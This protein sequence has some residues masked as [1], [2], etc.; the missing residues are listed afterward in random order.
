MLP[1]H[2]SPFSFPVH[3]SR[4]TVH[5]SSDSPMPASTHY[6]VIIIGTG[7][8]G[9]TL[10]HR[11]AP[12]GKRILLLERGDYVPRRTGQLEHAGGQCRGPGTRP[13]RPGATRTGRSCTRTPTTRSAGTPSST[14]PRC[15]GLRREDFGEMRHHGGVSPAWPISYDDL[16]PY[17]T[18]AEHLYQ[19]HGERGVDPTEPPAE[20]A[21]PFIRRSVTSRAF[22]SCSEDFAR[23][24]LTPFHVPLG[25]MLDESNPLQSRCIR[26]STCDGLPCLV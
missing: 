17:Y 15:S 25:V 14:E 6:D 22:S 10:A 18:E 7:A 1:V 23:L 4:F 12:S 8:G 24:G 16:E 21:L 11:L 3:C 5:L 26:C 20:R 2:H 9:G 13:R 19:V